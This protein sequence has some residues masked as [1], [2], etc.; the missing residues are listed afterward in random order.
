MHKTN[1]TI[2]LSQITL[3]SLSLLSLNAAYAEKKFTEQSNNSSINRKVSLG[4]KLGILGPGIDL[5][6]GINN[7]INVRFNYN[8]IKSGADDSDNKTVD[9]DLKLTGG[10][11]MLD[12]IG[13]LVDYFPNK[14]KFRVSAG[15]YKNNNEISLKFMDSKAHNNI[16]IGDKNYNLSKDAKTSILANYKNLAPYLGLGWGNKLSAKSH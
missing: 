8:H 13:A 2:K 4:A 7:K 6:Y 15:L 14:S 10:H 11:L 16:K 9:K 3:V 5:S 12:T 1:I